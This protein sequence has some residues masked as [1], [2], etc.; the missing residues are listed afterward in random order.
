MHRDALEGPYVSSRINGWIDLVFGCK[1]TGPAAEAADNVF[2]PLT[3]E[4]AVA[5]MEAETDPV[6]VGLSLPGVRLVTWNIPAVIN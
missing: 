4:G 5:G 2:H 1:Q 3:Y 6:K